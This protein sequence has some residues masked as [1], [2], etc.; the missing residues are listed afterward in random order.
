MSV[1]LEKINKLLKQ[2]LAEIIQKDLSLKKG[3]LVSIIKVDTSP[4][5]RYSKVFISILPEKERQY[6]L[7]TLQKEIYRLQGLLNRRL[8]TKVFPK[9]RF[10]ADDF[11]IKMEKAYQVFRQIE[12]ERRDKN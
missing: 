10:I 11:G 8:K 2:H 5:L 4:D 1:R 6:V 12:E 3:V 9:I 7:A